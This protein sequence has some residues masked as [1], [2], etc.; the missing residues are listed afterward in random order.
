MVM[1]KPAIH[2]VTLTVAL[3]SRPASIDRFRTLWQDMFILQIILPG[4]ALLYVG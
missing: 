1:S 4:L 2:T 3:F